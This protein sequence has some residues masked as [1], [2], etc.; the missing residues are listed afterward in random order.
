M[1]TS[2]NDALSTVQYV[3]VHLCIKAYSSGR[4][5]TY[6]VLLINQIP[7]SGSVGVL[8]CIDSGSAPHAAAEAVISV[9]PNGDGAGE[10]S[11]LDPH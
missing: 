1:H 11:H 7:E 8:G 9:S 4:V 2:I 6:P 10:I 5:D 3:Y